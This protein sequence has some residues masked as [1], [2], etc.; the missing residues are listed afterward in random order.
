MLGPTVGKNESIVQYADRSKQ[1][2]DNLNDETGK[3]FTAEWI[4]SANHDFPM[5]T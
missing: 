2:T 5:D 1:N 3:S 4:L